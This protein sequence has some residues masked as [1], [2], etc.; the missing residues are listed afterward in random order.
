MD[1]YLARFNKLIASIFFF[2]STEPARKFCVSIVSFESIWQGKTLAM[3]GLC[4]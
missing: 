3:V 4:R 2:E 1:A